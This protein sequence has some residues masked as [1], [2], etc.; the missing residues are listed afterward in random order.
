M[1]IRGKHLKMSIVAYAQ[2]TTAR[3]RAEP[4]TSRSVQSPGLS[5]YVDAFA[6]LIPAEVLA[7]HAVILSVTTSTTNG[8]VT[9]TDPETL[10]FAF[11]GILVLSVVL[12]ASTRLAVARW[13]RLDW[14]R[15]M[16]PPLAFIGWTMLQRA[17]AFDAV[18]PG[19][20]DAPRTVAALFLSVLLG[21]FASTLAYKADQKSP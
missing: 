7:L 19:M 13:D 14:L 3:E 17:T 20:H 8:T 11:F 9:I 12:Y 16:I 21:L 18:M 15:V 6:A 4:G 2:L 1:R 10:R 5:T